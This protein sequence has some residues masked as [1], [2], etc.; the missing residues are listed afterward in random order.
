VIPSP[1]L[2]ADQAWQVVGRTVGGASK[3]FVEYQ[4]PSVDVDSALIYDGTNAFTI[5]PAAVTGSNILFTSSGSLFTAADVG[6]QIILLG[7]EVAGIKYY[8]R[9]TIITFNTATTVHADIVADFPNTSPVPAGSWG[10]GI[11]DVTGIHH[12][13]GRTVQIVGDRAV[14]DPQVVVQGGFT[15]KYGNTEGPHAVK[16]QAGLLRTPNP[17]MITL[18]PAYRDAA[19]VIRNKWKHWAT[20]EVALE[21]TVGLTINNKTQIQY[22]K[23]SDPMDVGP[24]TF[25]GDK[26][27]PSLTTSKT[28]ILTFEQE[29]PLPATV[30]AYFGELEVGD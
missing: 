20:V 2:S 18:Q 14:Y 22:R 12:L 26:A 13:E 16:I 4:I 10:L 5:T 19:G 9:A 17:K 21:D 29:L 27:L 23:P 1:D 7:Y 8:S 6:K 28:G 25:T 30:L 15:L 11:K 24:P 3:H